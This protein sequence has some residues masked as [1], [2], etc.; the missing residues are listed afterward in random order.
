MVSQPRQHPARRL[1][2]RTSLLLAVLLPALLLAAALPSLAGAAPVRLALLAVENQSA[3]PR[4]DYLEGIIR[5]VLLFD[6]GSQ[7]GVELLARSDLE[8]ILREQE[9]QLSAVVS[10][11]QAASRIGKILGADYLVK[12]EYVAL[13]AE[14]QV[15]VR[16]LDVAGGRA[17]VFTERG[18]SENLLHALA[19]RILQR[20]TGNTVRLQ[21]EQK[22]RS[23]LSLQDEK[24]GKISLHSNLIDA[25]IF[26]DEEFVGYTTGDGRI[27]FMIENVT[28][29]KHRVRIHLSDF[30][31]VKEPEITF[32]DWE[33]SVEV[34]P[35]KNVVVRS[36]ARHFNEILYNLQKLLGEEIDSSVLQAQGRVQRRHDASFTDRQGRRVD[37]QLSIDARLKDKTLEVQASLSYAGK[38]YPVVLSA[39][40]DE[41]R[42]I[43][44][45]VELVEVQIEA[46]SG[47]LSY[48]IWRTDIQQNMFR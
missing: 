42:E 5:G 21:S 30:G 33:D 45:Q 36:N 27:P 32:H 9:L 10:D 29:G 13:G 6:L 24:P 26:L 18:S 44:R 4:Y 16:L 3:N 23:I 12:A 40:V 35:G 19:E 28:P 34:K 37:L 47:D 14:V 25:E 41:D 15:T 1:M 2:R 46:D 17:L 22:E 20:L 48:Q 31:V 11:A 43:R 8:A 39:S 7:E 38:E